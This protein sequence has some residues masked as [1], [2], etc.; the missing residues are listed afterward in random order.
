MAECTRTIASLGITVTRSRMLRSVTFPPSAGAAHR[1]TDPPLGPAEQSSVCPD[2]V[3]VR[4]MRRSSALAFHR[5]AI[6]PLASRVTERTSGMPPNRNAPAAATTV[7]SIRTSRTSP[8]AHPGSPT[9]RGPVLAYA[10]PIHR[11]DVGTGVPRSTRASVCWELAWTRTGTQ[12]P[13]PPWSA[14][15]PSVPTVATSVHP[16]TSPPPSICATTSISTTSPARGYSCSVPTLSVD[17]IHAA[18]VKNGNITLRGTHPACP[19]IPV[20]RN[21]CDLSSS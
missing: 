15:G 16:L 19:D 20:G 18:R 21:Y 12:R 10:S 13:V 2:G 5:K 6:P 11:N 7:P 14:P 8:T 1:G 4:M 9:R 3:T 17:P